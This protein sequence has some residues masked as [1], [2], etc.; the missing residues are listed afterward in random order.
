MAFH[1]LVFEK[2][3]IDLAKTFVFRYFLFISNFEI[4]YKKNFLHDIGGH[5]FWDKGGVYTGGVSKNNFA[6]ASATKIFFHRGVK[7]FFQRGV[8]LVDR[9]VILQRNGKK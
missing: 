5:G 3:I 8:L 7:I 6:A 1:K 9:G 2:K 4:F